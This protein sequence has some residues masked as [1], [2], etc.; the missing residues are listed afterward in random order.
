MTS[1]CDEGFQGDQGTDPLQRQQI[2]R[3]KAISLFAG[4]LDLADEW[5]N[6]P[7]KALGQ[8]TPLNLAARASGLKAVEDLSHLSGRSSGVCLDLLAPEVGGVRDQR[9]IGGR[10]GGLARNGGWDR[11]DFGDGG[12]LLE[13]LVTVFMADSVTANRPLSHF[14]Q[15]CEGL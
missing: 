7:K 2:I 4:N 12:F 13:T 5:L 15:G 1:D 3:A 6:T 10:F 8:A 14:Y 9:K 11:I